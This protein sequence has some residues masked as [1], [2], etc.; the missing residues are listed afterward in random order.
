M[1]S[2]IFISQINIKI[3]ECYVKVIKH[4]PCNLLHKSVPL[5]LSCEYTLRLFVKMR[6]VGWDRR[7]HHSEKI[8]STRKKNAQ[9]SSVRL[10]NGENLISIASVHIIDRTFSCYSRKLHMKFTLSEDEVTGGIS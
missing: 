7:R 1:H 5:P 6:F 10:E 4:S 3:I 9:S 8:I 2:S